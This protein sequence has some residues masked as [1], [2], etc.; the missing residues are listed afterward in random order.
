MENFTEI[1]N[2]LISYMNYGKL[3]LPTV[4]IIQRTLL[5]SNKESELSEL[6]EKIEK[7][8]LHTRSR[9]SVEQNSA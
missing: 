7:Q 8:V 1:K 5:H 6:L 4:R 2:K 9:N 3:D